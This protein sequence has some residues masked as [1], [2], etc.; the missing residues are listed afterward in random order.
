MRYGEEYDVRRLEW[1]I[2]RKEDLS[3]ERSSFLTITHSSLR[4]SYSSPYRI[5]RINSTSVAHSPSRWHASSCIPFM[6]YWIFYLY[7][8]PSHCNDSQTGDL[9]LAG[10]C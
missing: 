4:T 3:M 7:R 10:K 5:F 6:V 8:S 9:K 1:V 2:V